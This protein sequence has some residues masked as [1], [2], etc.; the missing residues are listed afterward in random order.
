MKFTLRQKISVVFALLLLIAALISLQS[1]RRFTQLGKS[2]DVILKENYRSVIAC[3]QMMDALERMDSGLLFILSGFVKEGINQIEANRPRFKQALQS[4]LNNLTLPEESHRAIKLR[5]FF[6]LYCQQVDGFMKSPPPSLPQIYFESL[7]PLFKD[8]KGKAETILQMNQENMNAANDRARRKAAQARRDM[9]FFLVLSSFIAL[10]VMSFSNH[11]IRKPIHRLIDSTQEIRNGNLNLVIPVD[12]RDEIGQLSE[13][14]NAMVSSLRLFR[15]SDQAKLLNIQRSTQEA[16][17]N[18]PEA[19]AIVDADGMIAIATAAARSHFKLVPNTSIGLTPYPWLAEIQ[20]DLMNN[21]AMAGNEKKYAIIQQFSNNQEKFYKPRVIPIINDEK[22][23]T[24]SI[25]MLEDVTQLMQNDEIKKDLFSTI[26]HQLKTPLTSI[27][28]A[29]HLMLEEN[30]G[31]LNE[32]QADLLVSARDESDRLNGIIE[33]LLDMRRLESG[34]IQLN[35]ASV[36]AYGLVEEAVAP[37]FRQAQDKGIRLEIDLPADL[38]DVRADGPRILYVFTNLLS[39]AIKFSP[40]G[41]V[42]RLSAKSEQDKVQ[43]SVT[44]NGSGIPA[45]YQ[46]RIFE[47]FFRVPGQKTEGGVG[48]G[49]SIAKEIITAHRG[50][51]S[52]SSAEGRTTFAFSLDVA[53]TAPKGVS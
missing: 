32:K 43:F 50:Q 22:E 14:F 42:V 12:T 46:K 1:I 51:I 6:D 26:S 7:F 21:P 37:F 15:R 40:V 16:F 19:I 9:Y 28:M 41:S 47:K 8:I 48:L 39:N 27:R 52:F 17:Q 10:L 20:R 5:S 36:S 4:E 23:Q 25:I 53:D 49:L 44:D 18:L 34:N 3:Q 29:L 35:L 31:S 30:V 13:A 2:I 11:W 45:K 24:G 38:P 33:D